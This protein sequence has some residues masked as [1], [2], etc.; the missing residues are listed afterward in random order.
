MKHL[1][2]MKFIDKEAV[3]KTLRH[4]DNQGELQAMT[5]CLNKS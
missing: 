4:I 2:I 1:I 3:E 5:L